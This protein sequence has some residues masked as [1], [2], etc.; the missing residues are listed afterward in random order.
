MRYPGRIIWYP[1]LLV[2]V[3]FAPMVFAGQHTRSLPDFVNLVEQNRAAV[4]NVAIVRNSQQRSGSRD[5]V[6]DFFEDFFRRFAPPSRPRPPPSRGSRSLG[7]GFILSKDGYVLTNHHVVEGA[8]EIV[9]RL[10]DRREL[11]AEVVGF[12]RLSDLALLKVSADNLPTVKLG[13]SKDVKVGEW[14]VAIGSP[15]GFEL[16]VTQGIVSAIG[17]SLP[18]SD[19]QNYVPFIQTDVAINPGNSGGPLFNLRGEVIG[20]N[21]QIYTRTGS[22]AGISF[23]VPIDVAMENVEQL[24]KRGK[25]ARGWLGVTIQDVNRDLAESFG[26]DKPMGALVSRVVEDSPAAK[27]GVRPGDIVLRFNGEDIDLS[28]E[29]PHIVGRL[30]PETEATMI[31]LRAG[32][33]KTFTVVLGDLRA[34]GARSENDQTSAGLLGMDVVALNAEEID[35]VEDAGFSGGVRVTR[36]QEGAAADAGI[37]P[38]DLLIEI[39][40]QEIDSVRSFVEIV[41]NLRPGG[42]VAVLVYRQNSTIYIPLRI[43]G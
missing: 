14:V 34:G 31:I 2:A 18:N 23:A 25:V 41:T 17:R 38:G 16:S 33:R 27:A 3:A 28:A 7:A 21:S 40:N 35:R 22:Y 39:A 5:A 36:I 1:M 37:R 12:D 10:S 43:P 19:N 30:R 11:K 13:S 8:D 26:L 9:V 15:Y 6:P 32:D 24:K 4:V 20:V 42:N 29:L